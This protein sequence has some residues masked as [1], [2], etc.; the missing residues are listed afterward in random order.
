[1]AY[2]GDFRKWIDP[3]RLPVTGEPAKRTMM[4][5][6]YM[7]SAVKLFS[8]EELENMLEGHRQKNLKAGITGLL[9]YKDGNF[10][11]VLE[12][13][14]AVVDDLFAKIQRDPRHRQIKMFFRESV[15]AREFPNWSMAFRNLELEK[16]SSREGFNSLLNQEEVNLSQFSTKVR[17]F[18][19]MFLPAKN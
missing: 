2:V 17:A 14:T 11:Q 10:L 12:G 3:V 9:L 7:S 5:L 13:E 8:P 16:D 15:P 6:I 4:R 1:L 19:Q 18:L